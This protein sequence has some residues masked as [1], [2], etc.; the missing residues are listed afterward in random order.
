[1]E[2]LH[3]F[4]YPSVK[5]KKADSSSDEDEEENEE[6]IDATDMKDVADGGSFIKASTLKVSTGA[7]R[8]VD[9]ESRSRSSCRQISNLWSSTG[10]R[11]LELILKRNLFGQ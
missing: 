9:K 7:H 6:Y 5:N 2:I 8:L 4:I 11:T 1:M 3:G 10:S